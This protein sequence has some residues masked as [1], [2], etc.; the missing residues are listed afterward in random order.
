MGELVRREVERLSGEL[1]PRS[2]QLLAPTVL[3]R[4]LDSAE[5]RGLLDRTVPEV[6]ASSG[7]AA[8][9]LR[10]ERPPGQGDAGSS[11]ASTWNQAYIYLETIIKIR[12]GPDEVLIAT[13]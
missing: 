11:L 2:M 8:V 3:H 7:Q 1:T 6:A 12:F 10:E 5:W 9:L 13:R 4:L